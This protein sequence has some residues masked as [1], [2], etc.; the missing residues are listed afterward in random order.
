MR[1]GY[2][3][4]ADLLSVQLG[5]PAACSIY[6][7]REKLSLWFDRDGFKQDR[8]EPRLV[9]IV[10]EN[11]SEFEDWRYLT[12]ILG[13]HL[14]GKLKEFQ[15]EAKAIVFPTDLDGVSDEEFE[16]LLRSTHRV[17]FLED[18]FPHRGGLCLA[19]LDSVRYMRRVAKGLP[20]N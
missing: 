11:F 12:E 18:A 2:S 7:P 17:K 9:S 19:L 15:R 1:F 6:I 4:L 14:S 3:A 16:H 20:D 10:M 5:D 13:E 8:L